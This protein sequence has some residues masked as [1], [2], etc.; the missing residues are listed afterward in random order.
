[1]CWWFHV[2]SFRHWGYIH[3]DEVQCWGPSCL[4][5]CCCCVWQCEVFLGA[6]SSAWFAVIVI[7]GLWWDVAVAVEENCTF[8]MFW[9]NEAECWISFSFHAWIFQWQNSEIKT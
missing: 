5:G 7:V 6:L 3:C 4:L 2:Y 9:K 8:I 1:L